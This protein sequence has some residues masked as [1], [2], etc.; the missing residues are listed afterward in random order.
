MI[1]K[2]YETPAELGAAAADMAA[3][4]L[5][6]AIAARGCA[7]LLLSTGA[8][9]FDT[10]RELSSRQVDWSKVEMFHLDEYIG[11]P[12]SHPAS[13]RSYLKERLTRFV[14]FKSVH[15]ICPEDGADSVISQ[16]TD[17]IRKAPIDLGLIGVG[18]NAHIA[19]NDPPADF[20]SAEAF[21][22]VTLDERCKA[23]Q[24]GE[25]WYKSIEDVPKTA[26]SMTPY[27]IMQCKRIISC[28]P[29]AVKADAVK[30]ML[31]TRATTNMVPATLLKEH[32]DI[33]LM[34]DRD[35]AAKTGPE[36]LR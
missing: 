20:G 3:F 21:F 32:A 9:Q 23:Q 31:E 6:E 34:L 10:L 11:I 30:A 36:F 29:Y 19:F 33:T 17:E 25:G 2:I 28:V 12:E 7:R 14:R 5:N 27:Q 22:I 4:A 18:E 1:I 8:S 26:I 16:L 15:F 24:M 35:S 13:F